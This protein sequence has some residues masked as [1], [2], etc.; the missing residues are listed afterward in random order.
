MFIKILN[1]I[2]TYIAREKNIIINFCKNPNEIEFKILTNKELDKELDEYD[3][4]IKFY[5]QLS[6][7][8]I[9]YFSDFACPYK[10]TCYKVVSLIQFQDYNNL[11][12]GI[13]LKKDKDLDITFSKKIK[14]EY[15]ST[16]NIKYCL[17]FVK[18]LICKGCPLN[19]KIKHLNDPEM[20]GV[21]AG[22][23][24]PCGQYNSLIGKSKVLFKFK[25]CSQKESYDIH[26]TFDA[27]DIRNL[28]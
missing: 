13:T 9:K 3:V 19:I 4:D 23:N 26:M 6:K 12:N 18:C 10:M 16:L 14:D 8:F 2:K 22:P 15:V 27:F 11:E 25:T 20:L 17:D 1:Y 7:N 5:K 28:F 21:L 24:I